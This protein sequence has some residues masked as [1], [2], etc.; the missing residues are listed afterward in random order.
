VTMQHAQSS[1]ETAVSSFLA[2]RLLRQ[3]R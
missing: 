1:V 2:H 3:S